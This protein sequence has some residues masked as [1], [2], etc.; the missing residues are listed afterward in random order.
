MEVAHTT[1]EPPLTLHESEELEINYRMQETESSLAL[2]DLS[3]SQRKCRFYDEPI[4]SKLPVFSSS[5]CYMECRY[6]LALKLCG[7][8]PLFYHNFNGKLC[9]LK[10][11]LCIAQNSKYLTKP[12]SQIGCD[13]PQP[14]NIIIYFP[15]VPKFTKWSVK[16]I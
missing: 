9:D 1:M 16:K 8:R 10:G 12:P 5:L 15:Q 6:E 2:R 4:S 3:P 14:C 11:L 7:C 13:C